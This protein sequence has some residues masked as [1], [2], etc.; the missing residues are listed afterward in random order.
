MS[1]SRRTLLTSAAASTAVAGP[2]IGR[3]RAQ[4]PEFTLKYANNAPASHPMNVRAH[5]RRSGAWPRPTGAS[6]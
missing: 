5:R 4:S 2:F 1:I 3:A 6:C